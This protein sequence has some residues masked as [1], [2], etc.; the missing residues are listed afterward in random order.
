MGNLLIQVI[1]GDRFPMIDREGP[2]PF[3]TDPQHLG[4]AGLQ[5]DPQNQQAQWRDAARRLG[6][7]DATE[8]LLPEEVK[9]VLVAQMQAFMEAGDYE[10]ALEPGW[11]LAYDDPWNRDHALD[12]ALCLQHLGDLESACRFYGMA[13]LMDATDAYCLYRLGE[14]LQA[15]GE[16]QEARA[17]FQAAIDLS[18]EDDACGEVRQHA[19]RCLDALD[20]Q[21]VRT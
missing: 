1:G 16:L 5:M 18:R 21:E 3:Q 2:W 14:C 17:T 15:L 10:A 19:Q 4:G 11:L 12:F 7:E 13:L 8:A 20:T 9:P 6:L